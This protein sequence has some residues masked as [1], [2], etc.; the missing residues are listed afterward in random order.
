MIEI[1]IWEGA[2]AAGIVFWPIL[3][4]LAEDSAK[5][6]G[7]DFFKDC[8]KKVIHLPEKDVQKEAYLTALEAFLQIFQKELENANYQEGQIKQYLEPI[9]KFIKQPKVAAI[10]GS[11]FEVNCKSLDI[12]FLDQTWQEMNLPFLPEYFDWELI[13]K[14]YVQGVKQIIT[15]SEKLRPIYDLQLQAKQAEGIEALVGILPDF[16]LEKYAEGL[17]ETYENLR[18]DALDLDGSSYNQLRLW[19]I[20]VPQNIKECQEI[21]PLELPKENQQQFSKEFYPDLLRYTKEELEQ[22]HKY[23]INQQSRLIWEIIGDPTAKFSKSLIQHTVILGDPGSGKS[24]LLQYLA[25]TWAKRPIK[26]LSLYPLPL[27]IE[28][29]LYA[30]DKQVGNCKDLLS[31]IHTGNVPCQLDQKQLYEKLKAGSVIALFDGIDEIFDLALRNGIVQD[32]HRFSNDYPQV[33]IITTSRRLGYKGERLRNAGFRH[34]MLQDLEIDQIKEFIEHWHELTFADQSDK[35]R[36]KK[37]LIQAIEDSKAIRELAGN[38]L[39]LTMMATVTLS[40]AK[41][42]V[43]GAMRL[44]RRRMQWQSLSWWR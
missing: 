31:F 9:K 7:K 43:V 33:Q 27:L 12:P 13:G 36:K 17:R 32:I 20:F 14:L 24:T 39:L 42:I 44:R 2:K 4:S 16:N 6:Y 38:P 1:L 40:L 29:R 37:R 15:K 21:L 3:K 19:K 35:V 26:E 8:L 23:Y 11:A 22:Y 25:L 28:L 10:L 30:A 34:F 41:A 18:L 5:D